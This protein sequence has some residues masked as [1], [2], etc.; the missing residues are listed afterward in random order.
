MMTLAEKKAARVHELVNSGPFAGMSEAFDAY[1]GAECW[2]DPCY[3]P[4]ASMWAAGWKAALR[5]AGMPL[6]PPPAM[7]PTGEKP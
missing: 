3:S 5:H 1:M 2:T 6:P 7:A 4:D